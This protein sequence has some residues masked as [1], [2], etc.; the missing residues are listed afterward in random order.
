MN[1]PQTIFLSI[2][3]SIGVFLLLREVFCWYFKINKRLSVLL[4]IKHELI[5]DNE[6]D[7]PTRESA[8]SSS[9]LVGPSGKRPSAYTKIPQSNESFWR[10]R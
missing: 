7:N 6:G 8:Q 5:K 9:K 3:I 1:N 2:A 4:D 10:A